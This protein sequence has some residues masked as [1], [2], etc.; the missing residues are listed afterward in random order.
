[1]NSDFLKNGLGPTRTPRFSVF[2]PDPPWVN[3]EDT[4]THKIHTVYVYICICIS[5]VNKIQDKKANGDLSE[6][7]ISRESTTKV[8]FRKGNDVA[9]GDDVAN[10]SKLTSPKVF[11]QSSVIKSDTNEADSVKRKTLKEVKHF[12]INTTSSTLLFNKGIVPE[13]EEDEFNS[14]ISPIA[15]ARPKSQ[16]LRRSSVSAQ[17]AGEEAEFQLKVCVCRYFVHTCI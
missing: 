7:S 15:L 12:Q 17:L 16:L 14:I 10:L 1:M 13:E 9:K 4:T 3:L 8:S 5:P 2:I 6:A 11:I